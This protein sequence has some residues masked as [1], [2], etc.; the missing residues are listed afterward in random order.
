MGRNA[1]QYAVWVPVVGTVCIGWKKF[2]GPRMGIQESSMG[3]QC[4]L[5]IASSVELFFCLLFLIFHDQDDL[6]PAVSGN[7]RLFGMMGS[8]QSNAS[9]VCVSGAESHGQIGIS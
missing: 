4:A 6:G 3:T 2:S 7:A 9:V 5:V 1:E 8:W